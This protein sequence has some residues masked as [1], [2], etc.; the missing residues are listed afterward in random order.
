MKPKRFGFDMQRID[1][2]FL[3]MLSGSGA[4]QRLRRHEGNNVRDQTSATG[5]DDDTQP[6]ARHHG[7]LKRIRFESGN[8]AATFGAGRHQAAAMGPGWATGTAHAE[9][10]CDQ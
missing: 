8:D 10:R 5:H 7:V 6:W 3:Q 1:S 9:R 2:S 4:S